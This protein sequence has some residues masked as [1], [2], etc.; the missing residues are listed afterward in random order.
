MMQHLKVTHSHAL[1]EE[2]TTKQDR[3]KSKRQH[4][5]ERVHNTENYKQMID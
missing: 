1:N 3:R 2:E 5:N 4:V